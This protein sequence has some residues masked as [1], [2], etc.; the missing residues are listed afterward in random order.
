MHH[1]MFDDQT[2]LCDSARDFKWVLLPHWGFAA[3]VLVVSPLVYGLEQLGAGLG[4]MYL[5]ALCLYYVIYEVL[6]TLAHLPKELA[7]ARHPWVLAITR[8]HRVHHDRK[9][10]LRFNFNFALPLFDW[11]FGTLYRGQETPPKIRK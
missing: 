9:L 10:M 6:H 5:F 4:W 8:H 7:M 3:V 2:M 11:L 1:A